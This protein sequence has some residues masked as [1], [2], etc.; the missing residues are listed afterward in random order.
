MPKVPK[1][2]NS[3]SLSMSEKPETCNLTLET[4]YYYCLVPRASNLDPHSFGRGTVRL[5]WGIRRI[6]GLGPNLA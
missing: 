3:V 6:R 1:I 5:A 2:K 4:S